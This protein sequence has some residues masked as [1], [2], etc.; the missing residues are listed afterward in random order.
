MDFPVH[1]KPSI[2]QPA[3]IGRRAS[4]TWST[5]RAANVPRRAAWSMPRR[6]PLNQQPPP[7]L[8]RWRHG[9]NPWKQRERY[10]WRLI[11][12]PWVHEML[13][14]VNGI[15]WISDMGWTTDT[16]WDVN[17]TYWDIMMGYFGVFSGRYFFWDFIYYMLVMILI[18]FH[19]GYN[20]DYR[21]D[22]LEIW[23]IDR[24]TK[25]LHSRT[26]PFF[27]HWAQPSIQCCNGSTQ[28]VS[29]AARMLAGQEEEREL[30]SSAGWWKPIFSHV[31]FGNDPH[32]GKGMKRFGNFPYGNLFPCGGHFRSCFISLCFRLWRFG[33]DVL[34]A[35]QR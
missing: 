13:W 21:E 1:K 5:W 32:M 25:V 27:F 7:G 31:I 28:D 24:G 33:Y 34:A 18:L 20:L 35:N 16:I 11:Y 6:R 17:G 26:K 4:C 10:S 12:F 2:H 15:S 3:R 23:K 9:R 8:D 22:L 29:A 19:F 30:G 14:H